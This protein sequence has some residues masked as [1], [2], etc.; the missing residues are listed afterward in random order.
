VAKKQSEESGKS[1]KAN[2]K[3]LVKPAP[4][5]RER[6]EQERAKSGKPEQGKIRK[7]FSA[8]GKPFRAIG[9][10]LKWLSKY[11]VPPYFRQ[12][13][14][15]LGR[16]KWPT[17]KESRKLTTAVIIFSV[18]FGVLTGFLDYGLNFA[19]KKLILHQ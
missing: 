8:I 2:K 4:S 3:R 1:A 12:A 13:F 17:W 15:E 19:F 14:V 18:I 16:V 5:I 10:G 6:K 9:R 11:T 7:F